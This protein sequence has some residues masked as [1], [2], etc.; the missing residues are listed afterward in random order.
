MRRISRPAATSRALRLVCRHH[1]L[2][3]GLECGGHL[4][5]PRLGRLPALGVL[6]GTALG[7]F[8]VGHQHVDAA[9][10]DIDADAVTIAHQADSATRSSLRRRVADGQARGSAGEAPIGQQ[11]TSLAQAFGLD[12]ARG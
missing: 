5:G 6:F 7:Q 3:I 8:F 11:R 9:V 1:Q 2:G 4:A 12:V 10:R